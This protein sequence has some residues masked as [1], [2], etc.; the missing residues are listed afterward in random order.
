M[1]V[2]HIE[3]SSDRILHKFSLDR[4]SKSSS[5]AHKNDDIVKEFLD[6]S[7]NAFNNDHKGNKNNDKG[8]YSNKELEGIQ[9]IEDEYFYIT[10]N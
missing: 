4:S 3:N 2:G 1:Y 8:M 7:V 6:E 5:S 9:E 10:E